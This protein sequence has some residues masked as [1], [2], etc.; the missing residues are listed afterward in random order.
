VRVNSKLQL[1]NNRTEVCQ[2]YAFYFGLASPET[3]AQLW[4]TLRD[5]LGP[6]RRRAGDLDDVLPANALV[7]NLLR[8]ELLSRYGEAAQIVEEYVPYWMSMASRTGTLWEH[9]DTRASCNHGFASHAAHALYRDVL[10]VQVVDPVT[11]QITLKFSLLDLQ[12]CEGRIPLGNG[13]LDVRW[14]QED[15]A[16]HYLARVPAGWDVQTMETANVKL[17]RHP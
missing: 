3:H 7:G 4:E 2:Y 10:G 17:V 8:L 9:D 15:G 5:R 12:W 11:Q 6:I 1:T 13:F 14:W 16:L